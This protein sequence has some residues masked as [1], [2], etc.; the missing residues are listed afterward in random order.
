[1]R[2][3]MSYQR[4]ILGGETDRLE[5]L[6]IRVFTDGAVDAVGIPGGIFPRIGAEGPSVP[7]TR[8]AR[9]RQSSLEA[10]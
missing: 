1:M 6:Q 9:R 7:A 10:G 3:M 2:S 8:F 5:C 4:A